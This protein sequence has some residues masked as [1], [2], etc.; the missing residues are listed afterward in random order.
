MNCLF[1]SFANCL[2]MLFWHL[3]AGL[4]MPMHVGGRLDT[5]TMDCGRVQQPYY[6]HT[7]EQITDAR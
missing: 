6:L 5:S 4:S 1:C 3:T 2:E 7:V